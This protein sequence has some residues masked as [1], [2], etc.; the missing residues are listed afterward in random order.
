MS[1]CM[2]ELSIYIYV[3]IHTIAELTPKLGANCLQFQI[4]FTGSLVLVENV[5]LEKLL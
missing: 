3:Y 2:Y 5:R 4:I 1:V